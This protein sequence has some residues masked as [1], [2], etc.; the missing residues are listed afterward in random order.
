MKLSPNVNFFQEQHSENQERN[1]LMRDVKSSDAIAEC[2][3]TPNMHRELSAQCSS[4]EATALT[5][6]G[7]ES[8]K[9]SE[10]GLDAAKMRESQ[11]RKRMFVLKELVD[12]EEAY[13]QNLAML[14]DGYLTLMRDAEC[15][16]P[17]PEDLKDG[18]DKLI[19]GNIETIY[20]WHRE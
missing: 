18:K 12:T 16:I 5:F 19:F 17:M 20:E 14:V 4:N 6:S 13:V 15:E 11:L 8:D 9:P 7:D 3:E 10:D 1:S 2:D